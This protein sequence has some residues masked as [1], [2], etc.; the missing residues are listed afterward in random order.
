[1]KAQSDAEIVDMSAQAA[2]ARLRRWLKRTVNLALFAILV[3]INGPIGTLVHE[4]GHGMVLELSGGDIGSIHVFDYEVY[5]NFGEPDSISSK[6]FGWISY[7]R[8]PASS[9]ARAWV[10]LMGSG[11]TLLVAVVAHALM[12][13]LRPRSRLVR[14]ILICLGLYHIDMLTYTVCPVLGLPRVVFFGRPMSIGD[15]EPLRGAVKLGMS[16][17][18]FVIFVVGISAALTYSLVRFL[19]TPMRNDRQTA[20]PLAS[21]PA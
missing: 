9:D 4:L 13:L 12:W 18:I 1:M 14:Y 16:Q 17:N 15:A 5:P 21:K 19:L 20:Q 3:L 11:T 10:A 2:S 7:A 6:A 8:E